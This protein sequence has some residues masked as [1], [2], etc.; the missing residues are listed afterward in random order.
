LGYST[1]IDL[2]EALGSNFGLAWLDE[3]LTGKELPSKK[4]IVQDM[5]VK[6]FISLKFGAKNVRRSRKELE[7]LT[8]LLDA[9]V[10]R[11]RREGF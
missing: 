10:E 9:E 11:I 6:E 5:S 7:M 4:E 8:D 1:L 3:H 2:A